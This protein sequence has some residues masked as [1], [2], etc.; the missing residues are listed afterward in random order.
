LESIKV[1]QQ[2]GFLGRRAGGPLEDC[3]TLD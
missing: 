1:V 3:K 2:A